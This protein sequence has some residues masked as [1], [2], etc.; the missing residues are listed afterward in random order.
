[1]ALQI[2]VDSGLAE[3]IIMIDDDVNVDRKWLL[4]AFSAIE[5]F[6]DVGFCGG[7]IEFGGNGS[8]PPWITPF[9]SFFAIYD[10]GSAT[11]EL[12]NRQLAGAG[13][14][15]RREAWQRSVPGICRLVGRTKGSLVA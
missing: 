5:R 8:L 7:P 15:I 13:I 12:V 4:A 1:N 9:L 14:L 11:F 6:D 10:L 3:W 2:A